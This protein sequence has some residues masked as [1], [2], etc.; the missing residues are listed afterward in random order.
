M[1]FSGSLN[2]LSASEYGSFGSAN[3]V[4]SPT[5]YGETSAIDFIPVDFVG[6][7][8]NVVDAVSASSNYLGHS[9]SAGLTSMFDA[10][11]G[12]TQGPATYYTQQGTGG[13]P[14]IRF[15]DATLFNALM[16]NRNGPYQHPSWKQIRGG[17]HPVARHLR[18][19]NTMSIEVGAWPYKPS[20]IDPVQREYFKSTERAT[21]ERLGTVG[22][23][24]Y[25][26]DVHDAMDAAKAHN[27][28]IT[29]GAGTSVFLSLSPVI[30]QFYEPVLTTKHKPFIFE[31]PVGT[32]TAKVRTTLMNNMMDFSSH[33]L[34]NLLRLSSGDP[35]TGSEQNEYFERRN[36][37]SY[38]LLHMATDYGGQNFIYSERIYPREINSYRNYKLEKP[39]YEE[40]SGVGSNGYDRAASKSFWRDLQ[41]QGGNTKLATSDGTSRLR[42][43]GLATSS[44]GV[45]QNTA[46]SGELSFYSSSARQLISA[47]AGY[48]SATYDSY[49]NLPSNSF[50]RSVTSVSGA[51]NLGIQSHVVE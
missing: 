26:K 36:Q 43:D 12:G 29:F 27:Q 22:Y 18:L 28:P 49:G 4:M 51:S 24:E 13:P 5:V 33:D 8:T 31:M 14:S 35:T 3:R 11:W 34:N 46:F 6:L 10:A 1:A 37:K 38:G 19:N 42:T 47:S 2:F 20:L 23:A 45:T 15:A 16:L 30:R 39:N 32:E 41:I 9:S 48:L 17:E 44:L 40:T 7:N 21:A 25:E 50:G